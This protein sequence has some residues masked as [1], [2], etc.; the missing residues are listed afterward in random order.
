MGLWGTLDAMPIGELMQW[1]AKV[2]RSGTLIV[3]YSGVTK[4]VVLE[5]G[6]V[7]KVASTDPREYLGQL[8]VNF[9]LITEDQ[10][11]K[12]FVTQQ[13]TQVLL[14]KILTMTGICSEEQIQRVLVL[15]IRESI[16]DLMLVSEGSFEFQNDLQPIDPSSVPVAVELFAVV[17][18]GL[19]RCVHYQQI[20]QVIPSNAHRFE[21]QE[22]FIPTDLDPQSI[23]A[24]VLEQVRQGQNVADMVLTFHSL[25]YPILKRIFDLVQRGWL[26]VVEPNPVS[27]PADL[28]DVDIEIES[29]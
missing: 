11:Q 26:T 14:G 10:L 5:S 16:M 21:R 23:D 4:S 27:I 7:V 20:R 29:D 3:E 9:G 18:E 2:N 6:M 15:K 8:L 17:K 12:A 25:D 28:P 1:L 13:E 24:L 19:E 22:L